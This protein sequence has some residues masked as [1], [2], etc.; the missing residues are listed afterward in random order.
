MLSLH[1][2]ETGFYPSTGSVND[3][4]LGNGKYYTINVPLKDGVNDAVYVRI[5]STIF[6]K[7]CA[8]YKPECVVVQC[9]AD[10]ITGDPLGGFNLTPLG[11]GHCLRLIIRKELP[12]LVLGGGTDLQIFDICCDSKECI[13][14][15]FIIFR[16]I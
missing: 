6:E 2:Y 4:G 13:K 8:K 1:K 10:S 14:C 16:R 15:M 9:G 3:I 11:L 5:F 12:T 7:V